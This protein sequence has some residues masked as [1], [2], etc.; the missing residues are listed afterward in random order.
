MFKSKKGTAIMVLLL[1]VA[2]VIAACGQNSP[3]N[4]GE[5]QTQQEETAG[6]NQN[7]Q[8]AGNK[9]EAQDVRT[10]EHAMGTTEIKGTP[11]R[12]V[13]LYQGANDIAIA[14]GVKPV[15][16]VESWA[17]QPVYEYLRADLDGIP[18]VG[19]ETQPN[20]EEISKL[21]PDL[22]VASKLRHEEIYEQLSQ[23]APTITHETVFKFKDTVQMMGQALNKE[24]EA[25]KLLADW[26]ARVADFKTKIAAK[27]GDQWPIETSVLNFR[28]DHSRIY[29]T[30]Y[31]GDILEELGFVRSGYQQEE[32]EKGTVVVKLTDKESIPSM[33]A[34][35]FFVFLSD[36]GNEE[37]VQKTY[38]E[39]T[40]HP[41]WQNLKAVK[42]NQ[43][44]QIDEV[45]WNL[46][47]GITSAN[48]L[49]DQLYEHFELEK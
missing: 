16:I 40:N 32:A 30:G 18:L 27:L 42:A 17:E 41:L 49:L 20:L 1:M 28:S 35:V 10:I 26:D 37:A 3:K 46:G 43:V 11:Q 44:Y 13:T 23:I 48:L 38:E 7:A 39:W 12:V 6:E 31:A 5:Q 9:A 8:N 4:G 33:D 22:I 14:L 19:E 25:A 36:P 29:V 24:D 2:L 15:G 34:D 21:K 47:G 45:V